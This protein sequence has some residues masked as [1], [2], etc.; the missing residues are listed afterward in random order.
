MNLDPIRLETPLR[1]ED[2]EP[3][4]SGDPVRLYV[5]RPEGCLEA[6]GL[7]AHSSTEEVRWEWQSRFTATGK[8]AMWVG[9][10]SMWTA[11]AVTLPP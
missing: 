9:K 11:S 1:L 8:A 3:L 4:E 5:S 10:L 7:D 6:Y 2:V